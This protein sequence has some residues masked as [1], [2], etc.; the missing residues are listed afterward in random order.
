MRR[1]I[2]II[3]AGNV[4]ATTAMRLAETGLYD[5]SLVDIIPGMPAGKALDLLQSGAIT[6]SDGKIQGSNS[7]E[8]TANSNIVVFTAGLP[9]TPGLTR[10]DLLA[11]NAETIAGAVQSVMKF[12]ENPIIIMVSN[13]LDAMCHV[14]L[15]ESG[16]PAHRV[17]GMAGIL[18]SAR[19]RTFIAMELG[20]SVRNIDAIVLGG[21][22]DTMAPLPRFSTV[23]GVPITEL[24]EPKRIEAIVERT[25]NGGTEIVGRLKTGGAYYAP[26][27]A[28][29]EMIRAIVLDERKILPCAALLD[30]QYGIRGIYVGVPVVLAK[31]G[32][33]R[34]VE[35]PLSPDELAALHRSAEAVRVLRDKVGGRS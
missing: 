26:A 3:G 25:R 16:M 1:K 30:G 18:D 9:R 19:F 29:E 5:I 2:S 10:D 12:S 6:L 27:A 28:V 34:I 32:I 21:H 13:P 8:V 31:N 17:I 7:Y 4:G 22:G 23:A 24:I 15:K 14:A 11:K 20:V 33:D 35:L